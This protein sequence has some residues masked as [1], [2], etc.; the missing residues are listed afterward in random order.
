MK[1]V[2][3]ELHIWFSSKYTVNYDTGCWVWTGYR[4]KIKGKL[5]YGAFSQHTRAYKLLGV[6][7]AHKLAWILFKG[8]VPDGLEVCHTCDKPEC[9]NP[10]HLFLGTQKE[11]MDDMWVKGRG[12]RGKAHYQAKVTEDDVRW[13]RRSL[14]AQNGKGVRA[15]GRL[16]NLPHQLISDIYTFKTW[17]HVT[18]Y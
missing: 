16:L 11:N 4:M 15:I 12:Q 2:L 14:A 17:K 18:N 9:V 6:R 1:N 13:I 8:L 5:W 10:D 3:E 7:T